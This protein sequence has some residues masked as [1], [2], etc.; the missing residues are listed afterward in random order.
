MALR[1]FE[2]IRHFFLETLRS[3]IKSLGLKTVGGFWSYAGSV[4]V[5]GLV[6]FCCSLFVAQAAIPNTIG[7]QGRLKDQSGNLL[8]GSYTFNVRIYA[9]TTGGVALWSETQSG[10]VVDNGAFA[11]H[12]GSITPFPTSLDF[13]VPL[14]LAT[15]VNGDGEMTPR[16]PINSVAYALTTGGINAFPIEPV[17]A[18][19]GRMYYNTANGTLNYYDATIGVWRALT[20]TSSASYTNLQT[21]TNFGNTTTNPIVFGG[22]TS[23]GNFV[24]SGTLTAGGNTTLGNVLAGNVTSTNVVITG[25][26]NLTN[27][28][29]VNATGTN[30]DLL[31]A[32]TAPNATF[33]TLSANTGTINNLTVGVL[34]VTSTT[35]SYFQNL[36]WGN[37]S[38]TNTTTTN[39]Y[40]S[41]FSAANGTVTTLNATDATFVNVTSTGNLFASLFGFKI[42]FGVFAVLGFTLVMVWQTIETLWHNQE[43]SK[44]VVGELGPWYLSYLLFGLLSL[45]IF[46][47][48]NREAGGLFLVPFAWPKILIG[49]DHVHWQDWWLRMQVYEAAGNTR[50][51]V[52]MLLAAA[53]VFVLSMYGTRLLGLW[54]P[55]SF[56]KNRVRRTLLIFAWPATVLFLLIGM[57]TLQTSGGANTFNFFVVSLMFCGVF[58]AFNLVWLSQHLPKLVFVPLAGMIILLSLPMPL[59]EWWLGIITPFTNSDTFVI[60]PD[61]EAAL[62]YLAESLPADAVVQAH[63]RNHMDYETPYVSL[64][65]EHFSYVGG[66]G[67]LNSHNQ[68]IQDRVDR[69]EAAMIATSAARLKASF[70][71]MGV[72]YFYLTVGEYENLIKQATPE[73]ELQPVFRN[74]SNVILDVE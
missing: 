35:P 10:V 14:Y 17:S 67:I 58:A 4:A 50:N 47:P 33:T 32:L 28:L 68:P 70:Q 66:R 5:L 45:A 73:A 74:A 53:V 43:F 12:L 26:S 52:I 49:A 71:K 56:W 19:G 39:L 21:V 20:A 23:T 57:N 30:L 7:Y 36:G 22:G 48:P 61:E 59:H 40:A 64:F 6:F 38:G 44:K 42:Y 46:L 8:N 69:L 65:S 60:R 34:T 24:I 2:K 31:G 55:L 63:P 51:I 11:V 41:V 54:P 13:N 27:I 62:R 1:C 18:T 72:N 3:S 29:F 37:A 16:V 15:E 9:S 25:L